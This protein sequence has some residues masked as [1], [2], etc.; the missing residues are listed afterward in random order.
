VATNKALQVNVEGAKELRETLKAMGDRRLLAELSSDNQEIAQMIVVDAQKR[1][2]THRE[3]L[4]ASS[5]TVT[6]SSKV[7]QVRL[8]RLIQVTDKQGR[9]MRPVGMGTEF[10]AKYHRRLVKNTGGRATIVRNDEDLDKVIKRVENQTRM[11][12]DTVSKRARKAWGATPVKVTKVIIGWKG[13]RPFKGRGDQAG[14][15][16]FPAIRNNREKA[17]EMY[18]KSIE[19]VWNKT[20]A[21]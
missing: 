13:Y 7:V 16:L 14:Y 9:G 19:K 1:A 3:Q 21:A 6:K 12:F 17:I 20:K 8:P 18:V 5:M 4:V 11:G 15:F 2:S 10:G